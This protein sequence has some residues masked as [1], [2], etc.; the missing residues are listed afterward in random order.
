MKNIFKQAVMA[1]GLIAAAQGAVAAG[2]AA[3]GEAKVAVCAACHGADGNS[4]APN[5]PKLAGLG[6][7]YLIKQL[8]DI[9]SG[10][11]KIVEMT[12]LL[13]NMSDQDLADMAAFFDQKPLQ[14]SGAKEL[15][16]RVNS[17]I[18]VDGLE[19]GQKVFRAGNPSVGMPACTGCHSP[20]GL[21]NSPAGYPRLSGQHADYIEKQLRD[22][23]AGNRVN[24]GDSKIMRQVAQHMSDAEIKAVA[25][26]IAGL[27]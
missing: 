26:Y 21:G 22:F 4:P 25:N 7:K 24:D 20:R 13:D 14:L 10:S 3:A 9:K 5:F 27:N 18:E 1:V 8:Q 17:G 2:D 6:E 23:R 16:V 11:R 12:G 19:L 15:K